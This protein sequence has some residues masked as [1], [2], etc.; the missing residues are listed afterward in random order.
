MPS[1]SADN[2]FITDSAL[3][4]HNRYKMF[5]SGLRG[6]AG[7][8]LS[9]LNN[10]TKSFLGMSRELNNFADTFADQMRDYSDYT[11]R[12]AAQRSLT[13]S[14]RATGISVDERAFAASDALV[15]GFDETLSD[16]VQKQIRRDV[17]AVETF[18]RKSLTMGRFFATT[19]ELNL[20]LTFKF[21]DRSGRQLDSDQYV[22]REINWGLRQHYN[23]ILLVAGSAAGL[24]TFVV[25]GGSKAGQ[26][27]SL[28]DYDKISG[29]IFH[30]NSKALLQP[31]NYSVS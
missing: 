24:E 4:A 10:G 18:L 29:A 14:E 5:L 17:A 2:L 19:E 15:A 28:D 11:L 20:D 3:E 22:Y 8:I 26:V 21:T 31:T 13:A 27:V 25:D 30:H 9:G 1:V 7:E 23:T 12:E 6:L 16:V